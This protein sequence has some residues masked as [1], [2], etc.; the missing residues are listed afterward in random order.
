MFDIGKIV[1][2]ATLFA[3]P[4]LAKADVFSLYVGGDNVVTP[5]GFLLTSSSA[6]GEP[7]YGGMKLTITNPLTVSQLTTL[8]ADYQMTIGTFGGGSPRFTIE[9]ASGLGT[10]FLYWG[11][12]LGGGSFGDPNFGNSSF[13]NTSNLVSTNDLRV[14]DNGFNSDGVN[15]NV[16]LTWSQFVAING[17]VDL[18]HIFLDLDS[19]SFGPEQQMLVNNFTVNDQVFTAPVPGPIVGAG[20]PGLVMALGG[21]IALRRR[22]R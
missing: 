7:G 3:M 22:R 14:F 13:A 11:T 9:D 18:G 8:S 2:A 6:P 21:L 16:G 15:P 4:G 10:A 20:L 1:L 5:S 17:G 12:P 19:G